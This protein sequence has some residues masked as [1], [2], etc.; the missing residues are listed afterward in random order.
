M[1]SN[2]VDVTGWPGGTIS[3]AHGEA[4]LAETADAFRESIRM[5]KAEDA[6]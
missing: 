3:A 1:L 5:L 2:G 4:E 6:I